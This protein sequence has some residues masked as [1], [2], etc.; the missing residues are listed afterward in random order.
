M[1]TG[2][3]LTSSGP[4]KVP[5]VAAV[6][7]P[8]FCPATVNITVDPLGHPRPVALVVPPGEMAVGSTTSALGAGFGGGVVVVVNGGVVVGGLVV[9]VVA[10]DVVVVALW[11]LFFRLGGVV[12]VVGFLP[13]LGRAVVVVSRLFG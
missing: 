3:P 10:V 2:K 9:A 12:V 6:D 1:P 13:G 11:C 4:L 7:W 8:I 5:P